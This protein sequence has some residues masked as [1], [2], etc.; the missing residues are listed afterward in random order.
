V[1]NGEGN[2]EFV[3]VGFS[4]GFVGAAAVLLTARLLFYAGIGPALGVVSSYGIVTTLAI[5]A[6][7][8]RGRPEARSNV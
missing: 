5:A 8:G 4:A 2:G 1:L 6:L 3:A 7:A